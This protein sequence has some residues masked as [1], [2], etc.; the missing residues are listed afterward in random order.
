MRYQPGRDT[1][2][3]LQPTLQ[4]HIAVK[5][6]AAFF[7]RKREPQGKAFSAETAH[8]PRDIRS[9]GA[10]DKIDIRPYCQI[11]LQFLNGRKG[12]QDPDAK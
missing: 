5:Q 10:L 6:P 2:A 1:A 7:P 8:D 11:G 12:K 3:Q 4:P 9:C